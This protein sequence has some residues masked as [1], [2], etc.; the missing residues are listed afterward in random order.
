MA[1]AGKKG[2]TLHIPKPTRGDAHAKAEGAAVTMY[3]TLLKSEVQ[4]VIR[5]ALRVLTSNRRHHR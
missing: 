4:V 2:D 3:R 1:M 5:Q